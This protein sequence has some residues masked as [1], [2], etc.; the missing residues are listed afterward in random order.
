[1]SHRVS[2]VCKIHGP[3]CVSWKAYLWKDVSNQNTVRTLVAFK[4][5]SF[6]VLGFY[7]VIHNMPST[8]F[9]YSHIRLE[10]CYLTVFH[11]S[12]LLFEIC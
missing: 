5:V 11:F 6:D 8:Y 12:L 9:D 2:R 4:F 3:F 1:M 10:L 7:Q